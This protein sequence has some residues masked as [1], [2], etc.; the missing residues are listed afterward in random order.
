MLLLSMLCLLLPRLAEAQAPE[1]L[2]TR[3]ARLLALILEYG[4]EDLTDRTDPGPDQVGHNLILD[5]LGRPAPPRGSLEYAAALL[6]ADLLPGR[7]EAVINDVLAT[8]AP[9]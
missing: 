9:A 2:Q 4:E 1:D 5:A 3:Q 7:A 6:T 8:Q